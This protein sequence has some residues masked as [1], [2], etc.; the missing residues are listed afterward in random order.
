MSPL[1]DDTLVAVAL[2]GNALLR[3][4]EPQDAPTQLVNVRHAAAQIARL[5]HSHRL[6]VTH[7][8]GPQVGLLALQGEAYP[9]VP[10][11]P[12]DVLGA[13]TEGM[14]GYLLEQEIANRLPA[15]RHVATLLT[16]VAVD[17]Q[18]PA[19]QHPTKPIGPMFDRERAESLARDRGWTLVPDGTGLR[20]AVPSPRPQE[21]LA[22]HA[23]KALLDRGMVV[24]CAGGGGV[25]VAR[26]GPAGDYEGVEAVIDKDLAAALLARQLDAAML[27]IATDVTAVFMDWGTAHARA[28][29]RASPE[30]LQAL[31]LAA[32]S[33]APKVEAACD[34]ARA[35]GNPAVI[36]S[37]DD[38]E[39]L[40]C[41]QAGT[42]VST[43]CSGLEF[44]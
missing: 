23:T 10:P 19:F 40:L 27:V 18:D 11:Y 6:V 41:G 31:P 28:I 16:R 26:T 32:G 42:W 7:G 5:A 24:I 15:G 8:N 3:R 39:R 1:A 20:R 33:I 13:E 9:E 34:F 38:I 36:G 25:P 14:V 21:V 12:L 22:L 43:G 37:L 44:A 30:A 2:G 35:T 29:R 4:G 17:R